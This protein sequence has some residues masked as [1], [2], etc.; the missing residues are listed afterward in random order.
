[1]SWV[2]VALDRAVGPLNRLWTYRVPEALEGDLLGYRVKVPLGSSAV[3]GYVMRQSTASV[4]DPAQVKA[5]LEVL[6]PYPLLTPALIELAFWIQGRY[7]AYLGQ[8]L[9]AM[10][11]Q[12]VRSGGSPE[13]ELAWIAAGSPPSARARR[14][15]AIWAWVASQGVV[16][17][18]VLR[19]QFPDAGPLLRQMTRAGTLIAQRRETPTTYPVHPGLPLNRWQQAAY[20]AIAGGGERTWLLEGV[21][22]SG[23]TEVYLELIA[24][25][26]RA[27]R[28][29]LVLVP[30]IALTPQTVERFQRRFGEAVGVW[31]SGLGDR[32][33]AKTWHRARL[34]QIGVL[35][36]ARSAVFVPFPRLDLI[37]LDEEH[38]A[39]YKQEEH[40]R[41]HA[42]EVAEARARLEGATVVLG[43]ATPDVETA[44]RARRGHIGWC[45]LPERVAERPLP[46]V[47]VVDLREELRAGNRTIF[48]RRLQEVV[49]QALQRREQVILLLNRRGY[50]TFVICRDCGE[51]LKCPSCAVSL[52]FHA[53]DQ[54]VHCH[55]C[56]HEAAVPERCPACGS[57][58]IRYFG[59]GT[60]RVV[61]EVRQR[62]PAARVAR[63]D[64]DAM[65]GRGS[66]ERLY[67]QMLAGQVDILVG[68]QMIAKGMDWP[69]VTVVG[70]IAADVALNLPDFRS[71]ER[72]FQL[73]VQASGRAGRGEIPGRVVI[74]TYNP[75]HYAITSAA[76]QNFEVMIEEEL[77]F[78]ES[79]GY[80]PY[81]H[82]W[83]LEVRGEYPEA[84]RSKAEAVAAA[85]RER[86]LDQGAEVLGPAPAPIARMRNW[87]RFHILVKADDLQR[88]NPSLAEVADRLGPL[89]VT[90]DPYFM[91]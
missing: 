73:L 17:P 70:V 5:V 6:D 39:T 24:D 71:G 1:M 23:K 10:V 59:A 78:R 76:Q 56:F 55:Y 72:T 8:V 66:Q 68:T 43:S 40:P 57:R 64:R 47:E 25:R 80:P 82:L 33:R 90:V 19:A 50:A 54:R 42:R 4:R 77:A 36:G 28:Q 67:R 11:P 38:E 30:E 61:E 89:T 16:T 85:V 62:W 7:L 2:E 48:S 75:E 60:E 53:Q 58:R 51:A 83:L 22:G 31:H 65:S 21:T 87:W 20:Q 81:R 13:A 26:L 15:Q 41:Y 52:T 14:Q 34:G 32:E 45:R 44:W 69:R 9:R 37:I 35:V 88:V 84:A 18:E 91:L 86:L 46:A 12:A 79:A 3:E 63:A 29:A 49:D 27:G 74:Q